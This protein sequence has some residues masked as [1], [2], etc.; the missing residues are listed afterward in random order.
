MWYQYQL[1]YD[2]NIT[3]IGIGSTQ[4]KQWQTSK[5]RHE[6]STITIAHCQYAI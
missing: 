6:A 4:S 5:N 1:R 2:C 3:K